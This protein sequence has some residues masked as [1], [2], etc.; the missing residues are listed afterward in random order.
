M[1]NAEAIHVINQVRDVITKNPSWME[2]ATRVVNEAA[3]MAIKALEESRWI[4]V[5]EKKPKKDDSY[6]ISGK[7][8]DG[9]EAV[10]ECGYSRHDGYFRTAWNFDVIAW[11][12]LPEPYKGDT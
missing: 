3:D 1:T 6:L 7:W 12:N 2:E 5:K 10:G 8:A 4:P 11:K 9:K